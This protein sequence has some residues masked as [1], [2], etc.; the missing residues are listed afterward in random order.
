MF[1]AL[2]YAH[3][4][5]ALQLAEKGLFTTT[6][7]P[8]VGCVIVNNGKVV[9]TGWHE[10][11]GEPHA[12]I[13]AL[14]AA[15]N[16]AKG[17][18]VYVTL[19]PC[20]HHGRTPP[21]VDAL[22]QAEVSKIIIAME[23]PNPHVNG[24]GKERLRMAGIVVQTG[25]LADEAAQL[26]IGFI[27]RMRDGKPW[28]RT[29]IA[30]SLDGRTALKNGMSQWITSEPARRD[31]H[32]WR[33]RSCA[34]LTGI[35]SVK[36]DNPQ[37]TVRYIETSRQPVRVVIDSNLEISPQTRLLQNVGI[38]WIFAAQ[39]NREK[40]LHLE[41]KGA[42]VFILPNQ[43]GRVDLKAMIAKLAEL[44]V[45]ELLVE[46]GPVLNGAL[47]AAGLIDE[48]IFYFAPNLLGNSAQ[49]IMKLPEIMDLT[50][51][52]NLRI[53]D[54]RRIGVDIRIKAEFIR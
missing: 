37:L 33:A 8:R 9:G 47:A 7:N 11:A 45:N 23:D 52:Y 44:G 34:I 31:G 21:C 25:L 30:A 48:I 28:V 51:K 10:R 42:H 5:H 46:A 13:N 12:E 1:T 54:M 20:S 36:Q 19:E 14:R 2:D 43:V 18:V 16:L 15:G 32:R 39:Y 17:A 53:T 40:E 38:T 35:G 4:S 27:T 49:A 6:P 26:N 41:N 22:I 24:Q 3:M 29:K 50:E